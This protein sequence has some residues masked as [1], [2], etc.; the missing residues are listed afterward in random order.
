MLDRHVHVIIIIYTKYSETV[1]YIIRHRSTPTKNI[2]D[3]WS[4]KVRPMTYEPFHIDMYD[5]QSFHT[6][7]VHLLSDASDR[8]I[9]KSKTEKRTGQSKND[10]EYRQLTCRLQYLIYNFTLTQYSWKMRLRSK[11]TWQ[12]DT[13][14]FF[15]KVFIYLF[16]AQP[17]K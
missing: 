17:L 11:K 14:T 4:I 13:S 16:L 8:N 15:F 12:T 1:A 6:S 3:Y 10:L 9:W 2:I 7:T 5:L